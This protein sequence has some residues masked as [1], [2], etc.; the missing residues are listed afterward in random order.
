MDNSLGKELFNLLKELENDTTGNK[1]LEGNIT[2]GSIECKKTINLTYYYLYTLFS[3]ETKYAG[4]RIR[5]STE[6]LKVCQKFIKIT[7]LLT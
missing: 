2:H 4:N 6:E 5:N 7:Q 1:H 3:K